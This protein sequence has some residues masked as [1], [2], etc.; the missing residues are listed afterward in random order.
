MGGNLD[1]GGDARFLA[2]KRL[3]AVGDF[4][5]E[6]GAQLLDV[7]ALDELAQ[8][9]HKVLAHRDRHLVPVLTKR[10]LA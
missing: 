5:V 1:G 10:A 2:L 9:L 4:V 3:V 7:V 6:V 8:G